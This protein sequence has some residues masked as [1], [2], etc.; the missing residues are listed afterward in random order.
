MVADVQGWVNSP[1]SNFGWLL[2]GDESV[3]GTFRAFWSKEADL[4]GNGAYEPRL[5]INYTSVPEPS[6]LVLCAEG[7]LP[8]RRHTTGRHRS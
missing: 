6:S 4:M 1:S 2:K 3:S 5:V 8:C 7:L